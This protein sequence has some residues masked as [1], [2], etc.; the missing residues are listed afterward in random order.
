MSFDTFRHLIRPLDATNLCSLR[1]EDASALAVPAVA[2]LA[3]AL[4]GLQEVEL[5]CSG[6]DLAADPSVLEHL[7]SL[8]PGLEVRSRKSDR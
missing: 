2:A 4:P 7:S 3:A 1:V 6:R 8:L 5:Y